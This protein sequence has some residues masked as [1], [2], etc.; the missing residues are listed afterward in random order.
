MQQHNNIKRDRGSDS[1]VESIEMN[2]QYSTVVYSTTAGQ[3]YR[4]ERWQHCRDT[5]IVA[6][7][8]RRDGDSSSGARDSGIGARESG[9]GGRDYG[10]GAK[11]NGTG[12]RDRGGTRDSGI[13]PKK[14][15][16]I[17]KGTVDKD[18]NGDNG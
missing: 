6:Q 8:Q 9:T 3:R 5:V 4:K 11:D 17:D 10:T 15:D 1:T 14:Q 13:V 7:W 12:N 18:R 16:N 2:L